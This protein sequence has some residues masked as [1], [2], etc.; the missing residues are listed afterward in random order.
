MARTKNVKRI[1]D[2]LRVSKSETSIPLLPPP[3]SSSVDGGE[4]I[5]DS[6][7]DDST[8]VS[9]DECDTDYENDRR[10]ESDGDDGVDYVDEDN[11]NDEYYNADHDY[12]DHDGVDNDHEKSDKSDHDNDDDSVVDHYYSDA[13]DDDNGDD[14]VSNDGSDS[15]GSVES[16]EESTRSSESEA[17]GI[18]ST[19]SGNDQPTRGV[20][21]ETIMAV[22]TS[23]VNLHQS[24]DRPI[25]AID[26][27]S[28]P[29]NKPTP[30][31]DS[32][33]KSG[34]IFYAPSTSAMDKKDLEV[35]GL[36]QLEICLDGNSF[37]LRH[38]D[39]KKEKKSGASASK[40]AKSEES[41]SK[42]APSDEA[43]AGQKTG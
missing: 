33:S 32:G 37:S 3:V 4:D 31:T 25:S 19:P 42:R 14:R 30:V 11:D 18:A 23:D 6:T 10:C 17:D 40:K 8:H 35:H 15:N 36:T 9:S 29:K 1:D 38:P 13:S 7:V 41:P 28:R 34:K 24:E 21:S 16:L 22:S 26:V 2:P 27:D 39:E 12:N 5:V 20:I 43:G